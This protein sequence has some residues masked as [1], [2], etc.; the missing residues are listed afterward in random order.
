VKKWAHEVNG[1]LKGRGTNGQKTHEEVFNSPGYKREASQN[2]QISSH[3][4]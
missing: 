2:K 1:I 3:P 4:N